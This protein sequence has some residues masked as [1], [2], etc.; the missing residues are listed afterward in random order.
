MRC[1]A[2]GAGKL[3]LTKGERHSPKG[4]LS[5]VGHEPAGTR[6]WPKP[7]IAFTSRVTERF[8]KGDHAVSTDSR[9]SSGRDAAAL[10][11]FSKSLM[12]TMR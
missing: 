7:R 2:H 10:R 5:R 3:R 4:S 6:S 1:R 12:S 9:C 8:S 11:D